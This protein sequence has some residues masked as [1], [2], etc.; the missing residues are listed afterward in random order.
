MNSNQRQYWDCSGAGFNLVFYLQHFWKKYVV[1]GNVTKNPFQHS[2]LA[3]I[4]S[5]KLCLLIRSVT[6]FPKIFFQD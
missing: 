4:R 3:C 1:C 2:P 6:S 5:I